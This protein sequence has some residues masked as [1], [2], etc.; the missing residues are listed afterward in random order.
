V[1]DLARDVELLVLDRY[2]T[3]VPV[4]QEHE[5]QLD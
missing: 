1:P 5:S 4:L 3:V 2:D